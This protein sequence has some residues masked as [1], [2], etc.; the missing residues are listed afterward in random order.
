MANPLSTPWGIGAAREPDINAPDVSFLVLSC[1]SCSR[2]VCAGVMTRCW[3][4]GGVAAYRR[5]P[6]LVGGEEERRTRS[7]VAIADLRHCLLVDSTNAN[8]REYRRR[9]L[10][11]SGVL[12]CKQSIG[13]GHDVVRVPLAQTQKMVFDAT[14]AVI[15][16]L[17]HNPNTATS[18]NMR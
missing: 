12:C 18:N 15:L 17:P 3:L 13:G 11:C 4:L 6:L 16:P 1:D 8:L 9:R 5:L 7:K 10:L 2:D 14:H